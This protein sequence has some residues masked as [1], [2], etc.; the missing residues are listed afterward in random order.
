VPHPHV[1]PHPHAHA[2]VKEVNGP[3]LGPVVLDLGGTVGA[4][5][6][7]TP[8]GLEGAEIEIRPASAA[9]LGT[10]VAVRARPSNPPAFAAVFGGLPEGAYELRLRPPRPGGA[11]ERVEV[12][13]G[14]VTEIAWPALG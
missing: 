11:V 13:G 6:V 9:W 8:A 3:S 10:H 7:R 12:I 2:A 5:I 14:A 4:L 1:H